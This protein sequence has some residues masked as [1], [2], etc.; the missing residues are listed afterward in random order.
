MHP[1]QLSLD[2]SRLGKADRFGSI[3]WLLRHLTGSRLLFLLLIVSM[4]ATNAL[5]TAIPLL[6]GFVIEY[7]VLAKNSSLLE[8]LLLLFVGVLGIRVV[9]NYIQTITFS[10]I[11]WKTIRN[12]RYEFFRSLQS[13][14][15][16]F[17][18]G[19][20]S[21]EIMALA[22]FDISMLAEMIDPGLR[23]ISEVFLTFIF[24]VIIALTQHPVFALILT[25]F[26]VLYLLAIRHYNA[27]MRPISEF[28]ERKWSQMSIAA[29][30]NITGARVVRAFNTQKHEIQKFRAVVEEFRDLWTERQYIQAR[31]WPLLMINILLGVS[32]FLGTWLVI[33]GQ[34]GIGT[35]L[36]YN[37]LILMLVPTTLNISWA[38]AVFQSGVAGGGRVYKLM[39]SSISEPEVAI[40]SF[41]WSKSKGRIEFRNVSFSYPG[42]SRLTL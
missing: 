15:L 10:S 29:Q 8:P 28:F 12:I 26:F 5:R 41:D 16:K 39:H 6:V 42:A 25:P 11:Q 36:G 19:T 1:T 22:T 37:G 14:P 23:M 40:R 7:V 33:E 35:L 38:I 17:H 32:F 30:D 4:V 13:K 3:L 34:L 9:F 2:T 20:R 31:Y 27:K 21:G 18:D 24:F